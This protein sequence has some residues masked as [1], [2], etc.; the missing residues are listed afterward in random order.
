M[1]SINEFKELNIS[2]KDITFVHRGRNRYHSRFFKDFC[3]YDYNYDFR[4]QPNRKI[5]NIFLNF[6]KSLIFLYEVKTSRFYLLEG[7][8]CLHIGMIIN[9][10]NREKKIIFNLAD[11]FLY[12][13]NNGFFTRLKY[14]IKISFLR[15]CAF[16]FTNSPLAYEE[17]V[18]LGLKEIY[19]YKLQISDSKIDDKSIYPHEDKNKN[20]LYMITR[21]SETGH[22]KG[23]DIATDIIK[24][25]ISDEYKYIFA[26]SE[27]IEFDDSNLTK[28]GFTDD[29][30]SLYK[31]AKILIC[32]SA[33]DSYPCVSVECI[34]YSVLPL[35]SNR[36]GSSVDLKEIDQNLV[37]D[38]ANIKD[39]LT[40]IDTLMNYTN[41]ECNDVMSRLICLHNSFCPNE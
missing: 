34:K 35:V 25:D 3:D 37:A 23:L 13:K 38:Y 10:F 6:L 9:L 1:K 15:K 5:I 31:K 12:K 41:A 30:S 32:P 17:L 11:P 19:Y 26:G 39:W 2:S 29:V 36:C 16:I 21:P 40:K 24:H 27:D 8:L 20:I 18:Q 28:I 7:G 22:I 14:K 33:Y 4:H